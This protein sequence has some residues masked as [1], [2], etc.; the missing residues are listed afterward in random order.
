VTTV[1][2]AQVRDLLDERSPTARTK[3]VSVRRVLTTVFF[4]GQADGCPRDDAS[5]VET[6]PQSRE[7]LPPSYGGCR[8]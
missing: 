8:D 3:E 5:T 1:P 6:F 2:F 4:A 7:N